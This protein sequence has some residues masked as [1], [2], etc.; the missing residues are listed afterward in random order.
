M[1]LVPPPLPQAQHIIRDHLV[2]DVA[3]AARCERE[4]ALPICLR[5]FPIECR[6][7]RLG[8]QGVGVRIGLVQV[9]HRAGL[10]ASFR[11]SLETMQGTGQVVPQTHDILP[12]NT[13]SNAPGPNDRM[14]PAVADGTRCHS[15]AMGL[16]TSR[17]CPIATILAQ[18]DGFLV[19]GDCDFVVAG[20]VPHVARHGQLHDQVR[21][22]SLCQVLP[23]ASQSQL[24]GT[25]HSLER[26]W[27]PCA[28]EVI[29]HH[30]QHVGAPVLHAHADEAR[31]R[32][33]LV[34]RRRRP[35]RW[36]HR[37]LSAHRLPRNGRTAKREQR[38]HRLSGAA[39]R[40]RAEGEAAIARDEPSD[41]QLHDAS[42]DGVR[43]DLSAA[44]GRCCRRRPAPRGDGCVACEEIPGRRDHQHL[45]HGLDRKRS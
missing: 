37:L 6:H 39:P 22:Q 34:L 15:S 23:G 21:R 26:R 41:P 19:V 4:Q 31:P 13:V 45:V 12:L 1:A 44:R 35:G 30:G 20:P 17:A 3:S 7:G 29:E 18:G 10:L 16:A 33:R 43:G 32:V 8:A 27:S 42:H 9:H 28:S 25:T 11:P 40:C 14:P 38:G 5:C 24:P 2:S 36:D